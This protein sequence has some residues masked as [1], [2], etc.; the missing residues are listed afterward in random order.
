MIKKV[1]LLLTLICLSAVH[2][3]P[4][5]ELTTD[6]PDYTESAI[7]VPARSV[8]LET[9]L[10]YVT[11]NNTVSTTFPNSL[12]RIGLHR[13]VELRIGFTGWTWAKLSDE[14]DLYF[15]DMIVESKIQLTD[16]K[17]DVPVAIILAATIPVG[18]DAVST[19]GS[20]YG[21]KFAGSCDLS[22]NTDLGINA[23]IYS[24]F[25]GMNRQ[26][27]AIASI[28]YGI[29]LNQSVGIFFE[30]FAE[31]PQ[32]EIWTPVFDSGLTFSLTRLSQLDLY[33]GIGLNS[34]APDLIIGTGYSIRF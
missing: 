8:Q 34:V 30:T 3:L 6:R 23:G 13:S 4:A 26:L 27:M 17:A 22:E 20:D 25:D 12:F 21:M 32:K 9:G 5:Q 11:E 33:A 18:D 29:S 16:K 14:R 2:V 15:N 10:E 28:S 1:L 31:M 24:V 7:T 19:G